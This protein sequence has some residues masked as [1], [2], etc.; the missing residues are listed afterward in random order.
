MIMKKEKG[1]ALILTL[2]TLIILAGIAL[3]LQALLVSGLRSSICRAESAKTYYIARAGIA[4]AMQAIKNDPE[5]AGTGTGFEAFANGS[6]QISV[7]SAYAGGTTR[8]WKIT[9]AGTYGLSR[10]ELVAWAQAP[11]SPP[12]PP[13]T[14]TQSFL[15]YVFAT[16]SQNDLN[17]QPVWFC[18]PST[19]WTG[20]IHTN[21]Y[22]NI[23]ANPKFVGQ[24]TSSNINDPYYRSNGTYSSPVWYRSLLDRPYRY[25]NTSDPSRFYNPYNDF[26]TDRPT[27][28]SSDFSFRGGVPAVSFP[29][30]PDQVKRVANYTYPAST[31]LVFNA[32]GTMTATYPGGSRT[33]PIPASGATVYIAGEGTVYGTLSGRA[34]VETAGNM[35]VP[36]NL[37]YKNPSQDILGL[38]SDGHIIVG[39]SNPNSRPSYEIDAA[40]IA[41]NTSIYVRDYNR[42]VMGGRITVKGAYIQK[43]VGP[44]SITDFSTGRQLS[45]YRST[46]IYDTRLLTNPPPNFPGTTTNAGNTG[47]VTGAF[48][49]KAIQDKGALGN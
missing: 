18:G 1:L 17:N 24:T 22:F 7:Q 36:T 49:I 15:S 6:F 26:N 47:T 44:Y 12:A 37:V 43:K 48:S 39:S 13:S 10:R 23:Y 30:S 35:Y 33:D 14:S 8:L 2:F 3:V 38:V 42:G 11:Y 41:L 25:N 31:T 29:A 28:G 20:K 19:Y 21:G 40:M 45:G 32:N 5:W 34:T 9:S 4:Y 16:D 27:S 46:V